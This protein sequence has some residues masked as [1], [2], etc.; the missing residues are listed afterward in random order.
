M[1]V[2]GSTP[3]TCATTG[4]RP[5]KVT[6]T[7]S[8]PSTTWKF[9]RM[10]PSVSMTNPEPLPSGCASSCDGAEGSNGSTPVAAARGVTRTTPG[11]VRL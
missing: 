2:D 4:S 5:E 6:C 1:S 8:A 3:T 7:S 11:A 10:C 9:V